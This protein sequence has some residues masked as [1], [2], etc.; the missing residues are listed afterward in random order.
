MVENTQRI[1][2]AVRNIKAFLQRVEDSNVESLA[3][4]RRAAST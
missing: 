3:A 4:Y 1:R 2:Q